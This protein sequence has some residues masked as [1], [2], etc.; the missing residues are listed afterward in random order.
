[1]VFAVRLDTFP[2]EQG[3]KVFYIDTNRPEALTDI[4]RHALRE[5]THLPISGE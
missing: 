1:M 2:I 3:A 5:F 4:R